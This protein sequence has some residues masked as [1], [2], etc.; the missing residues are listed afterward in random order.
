MRDL[1]RLDLLRK[2]QVIQ[3]QTKGLKAKKSITGFQK[4]QMRI[5]T[6]IKVQHIMCELKE[7]KNKPKKRGI[8]FQNLK[9]LFQHNVNVEIK[10]PR[11]T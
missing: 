5:E 3:S 2:D 10:D 8:C 7:I 6:N 4:E 1:H 9:N 11:L